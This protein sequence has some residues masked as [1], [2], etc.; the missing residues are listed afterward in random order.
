MT[1]SLNKVKRH[2]Q[3][4]KWTETVV[5]VPVYISCTEG[6]K[7]LLHYPQG[8]STLPR[9]EA[10]ALFDSGEYNGA[11]LV[12]G[13]RSG[14]TVVDIDS[15]EA[16]DSFAQKAGVNLFEKASVVVKTKKGW[17]FYFQYEPTVRT[18]A[19]FLGV[20]GVDI[21]ND[22]GNVVVY[23]DESLSC[24]SYSLLKNSDELSPFPAE[25]LLNI[26]GGPPIDSIVQA[27][28]EVARKSGVPL[29]VLL[30]SLL[31]STVEHNRIVP[32]KG[33]AEQAKAALRRLTPSIFR[34]GEMGENYREL[35]ESK[36]YLEPSDIQMGDGHEYLVRIRGILA[37]D[38]SVG[39][40]LFQQTLKFL[41]NVWEKPIP[42]D[43]LER[44][45]LH[46][47]FFQGG[48]SI[49][50][51]NPEW[52]EAYEEKSL[53][54][55][56]EV[57]NIHAFFS[58]DNS[59]G[60]YLVYDLKTGEVSRLAK[61]GFVQ[62]VKSKLRTKQ[63]FREWEQLPLCKESFYPFKPPLYLDEEQ[64]IYIINKWRPT[65]FIE[66]FRRKEAPKKET[67]VIDTILENL[68]PEDKVL[69]RFLNWL[70]CWFATLHKSK[71]AWVITSEEGAGKGLLT[72]H[73][74]RPI[75]GPRFCFTAGQSQLQ[76][77]F[78]G[79]YEDK[80]FIN[81]NEVS[82][83]YRDRE[84]IQN[85]IKAFVTD[86]VVSIRRMRRD[87]YEVRNWANMIFTSN[88]LTPID[89]G[90]SDRRFVVSRAKCSLKEIPEMEKLIADGVIVDKITEELP[91]FVRKLSQRKRDFDA[92][93]KVFNTRAKEA[94]ITDST[95]PT[96]AFLY[97]IAK[98]DDPNFD[99][100]EEE[101]DEHSVSL[102]NEIRIAFE[103]KRAIRVDKL[104]ELYKAFMGFRHGRVSK[105]LLSKKLVMLN[106]N[107]KKKKARFGS[108][109]KVSFVWPEE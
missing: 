52:K 95:S 63:N 1:L 29:A 12:T 83:S 8:W 81:F 17:H 90:V 57:E 48:K 28:E 5:F 82:T 93:N 27:E 32:A 75:V 47:N 79:W 101:L 68:F 7:K 35:F 31:E 69:D 40:S 102:L 91:D 53:I 45:L 23:A 61:S 22:G 66:M 3:G 70:S 37:R 103:S 39:T 109:V 104:Y 46:P 107:L 92:Y 108:E 13:A 85:K 44:T 72:D 67:P 60:D 54:A 71:V 105:I 84:R 59:Q 86:D 100:I 89:I 15:E 26:E 34:T 88:H 43:E 87:A 2:L 98:E 78:N 16:L 6:G 55:Q 19:R 65:P 50:A 42:S 33:K 9:A 58:S 73:I 11:A 10:E 74:I 51:Y 41:N 30:E 24:A 80:L 21:R 94:I 62:F 76:E 96:D 14:V 38:E 64:G 97:A 20:Q 77:D 25:I 49:W 18:T 99:Y 4:R 56:L 36:G 106:P